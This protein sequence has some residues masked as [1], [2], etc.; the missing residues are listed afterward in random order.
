MS[1]ITARLV[2]ARKTTLIGLDSRQEVDVGNSDIVQATLLNTTA[3]RWHFLL[4]L[5]PLLLN[6]PPR[7]NICFVGRF[8]QQEAVHRGTYCI[9]SLMLSITHNMTV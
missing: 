5:Q 6:L 4:R 1:L 8:R 3:T 7:L 2:I 9:M